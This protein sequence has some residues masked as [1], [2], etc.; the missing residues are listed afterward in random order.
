MLLTIVLARPPLVRQLKQEQ[1]VEPG[2][3]SSVV[4]D[5]EGERRNFLRCS[6][7]FQDNSAYHHINPIRRFPCTLRLGPAF[8]SS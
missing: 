8:P 2:S 6:G 4:N 7:G 3:E 5:P 1:P